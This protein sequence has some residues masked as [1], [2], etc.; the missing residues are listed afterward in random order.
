M[1]LNSNGLVKLSS[2][3]NVKRVYLKRKESET[4]KEKLA[5]ARNYGKVKLGEIA[6]F[7]NKEWIRVDPRKFNGS[8]WIELQ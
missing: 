2:V 7:D 6:K 5:N 8:A 4:V 1:E 3:Q